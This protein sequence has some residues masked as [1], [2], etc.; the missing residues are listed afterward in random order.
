M[1]CLPSRYNWGDILGGRGVSS[2]F[3]CAFL[4][5]LWQHLMSDTAPEFQW[6]CA[7][8]RSPTSTLAG[9]P[10]KVPHWMTS[11]KVS[12]VPWWV[13]FH[14]VPQCPAGYLLDSFSSICYDNFS[15]SPN[16]TSTG[17]FLMSLDQH[18]QWV[19]SWLPAL[20][21]ETSAPFSVTQCDTASPCPMRKITALEG[22]ECS[23]SR[24]SPPIPKS[25]GCPLDPPFFSKINYQGVLLTP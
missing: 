7:F 20:A 4:A 23:S 19:V 13:A 18:P 11:Q 3:P 15:E 12:L 22:V 10:A 1:S 17:S 5:L 6:H 8:P 21:Y 16:R 24:Y 25:N 9:F 2:W 14:Q